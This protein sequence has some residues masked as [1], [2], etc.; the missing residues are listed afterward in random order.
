MASQ[1]QATRTSLRFSM[2]RPLGRGWTREGT[3]HILPQI[4][5][6]RDQN[7]S[8]ENVLAA[9]WR[10]SGQKTNREGLVAPPGKFTAEL[11][12][13][14]RRSQPGV[15]PFEAECWACRAR[16]RGNPRRCPASTDR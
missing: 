1:T 9:G 2:K 8:E 7:I 16:C 15:V 5:E 3:P 11:R 12:F 13:S 14:E 10:W 6:F 4:R